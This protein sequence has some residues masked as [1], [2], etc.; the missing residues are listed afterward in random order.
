MRRHL[1]LLLTLGLVLL[2]L[3]GLS[4]AGSVE[5][6]ERDETELEPVRSSFNPGP[7][8]TRALYQLLEG[9]G[10]PVARWREK[11]SELPRR[12]PHATLIIVGPF[13]GEEPLEE[14]EAK[15]LHHWV[16]A[17]GRVLIVSRYPGEQF[18]SALIVAELPQE[19]PNWDAP[20]EQIVNAAS[21][22]LIVQPTALTRGLRGLAL[23]GFT[24][25][26]KFPTVIAAP[27]PAPKPETTAAVPQTESAVP[28]SGEPPPAIAVA[29]PESK[30]ESEIEVSVEKESTEAEKT[31]EVKL[32][33][34]VIHLGDQEGAVLADFKYGAGRV[35][36]LSDPFALANN[37]LARGANLQLTLN[38]V[39]ALR[40]PDQLI[41]FD[42]YHHGY[43]S[44]ENAL[45]RY[46]RGTPFW[47]VMGQLLL[48][49]LVL[50]YSYG[51]RFARP[52]PL[53]RVNRHSPL[54][55]VSSMANLQQ[56]AQ[57]RDLAM[58]NIYPRFKQRLCRRLGLPSKTPPA[59]IA[60]ALR[61]RRQFAEA[62]A[63]IEDTLRTS[64]A[65]LAGDRIDDQ[66]LV[67]LVATMR[68]FE[69]D[70]LR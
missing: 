25:R 5:F 39:N 46:F 65:V 32:S 14:A 21:D 35:L 15:A 54:E 3:I 1:S 68:R 9:S 40:Q 41:Y 53:P 60:A 7:T 23:S 29:E 27:P 2:V 38:L 19:T 31:D 11:F 62:A 33:A 58:E 66:R 44:E 55:F 43:P 50:V 37:G 45:V 30:P 12:A 17:G 13:P 49:A 56:I 42:E 69:T 22:Q 61:Q 20:P 6:D 63:V 36:F 57:A 67:E 59:Q 64:E 70:L 34:P 52:L 28:P 10:Y 16:A 47:W 48:L 26:L 8:G 4:A 51:K 18:G 24:A